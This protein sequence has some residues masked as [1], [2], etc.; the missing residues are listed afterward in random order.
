MR[1]SD[2]SSDV[3]SSDLPDLD[4]SE[5]D[6]LYPFL[7]EGERDTLEYAIRKT[8]FDGLDLIP[9]NLHLFQSEYEIAARMA[10]GQGILLNRLAQGIASVSDLY[11]VVILDPPPALGAI[12][13]SVLR[14]A[15]V[16]IVPVPPTV[17][18][19]SSTAAFL[20]MLADT[21]E[22]LKERDLAA[23]LS[24]L[25][26]AASQVDAQKSMQKGLLELIRQLYGNEMLRTPLKEDDEI[27][28]R[29]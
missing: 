5:D 29:R 23:Q 14:A 22:E 11:D 27:D 17:M 19:F 13:L 2:W 9:A 7:R 26:C 15:N 1:I 25:R 18:D 4:L 6:T 16:L 21:I 8:H 12:S 24:L 20:A 10:R 3:C 28:N